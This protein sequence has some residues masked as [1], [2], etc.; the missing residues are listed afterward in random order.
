MLNVDQHTGISTL[1][2]LSVED[3]T[4]LITALLN[5]GDVNFHMAYPQSHIIFAPLTGIDLKRYA[6]T[7]DRDGHH[8]YVIDVSITRMNENIVAINERNHVPTPWMAGKVHRYRGYVMQYSTVLKQLG[9]IYTKTHFACT[10]YHKWPMIF[11]ICDYI[12]QTHFP[13]THYHK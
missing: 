6:M 1:R 7:N 2:F 10:H 4:N 5:E 9:I 13:C 3:M 11:L 8:Q 12:Q